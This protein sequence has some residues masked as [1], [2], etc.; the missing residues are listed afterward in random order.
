MSLSVFRGITLQSTSFYLW[1]KQ[2]STA[3]S[4]PLKAPQEEEEE[5]QEVAVSLAAAEEIS[6]NAAVATVLSELDGL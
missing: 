4:C 5:I 3:A 1:W 6:M 2:D